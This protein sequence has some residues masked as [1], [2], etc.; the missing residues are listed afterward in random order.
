MCNRHTLHSHVDMR[1]RTRHFM[2]ENPQTTSYS[3]VDNQQNHI[4]C[5]LRKSAKQHRKLPLYHDKDPTTNRTN[6]LCC[7]I[8]G[9]FNQT[10]ITSKSRTLHTTSHTINKKPR[11][12]T[13]VIE[14]DFAVDAFVM[15]LNGF[16]I[17]TCDVSDRDMQRF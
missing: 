12:K 2:L 4:A 14:S 1:L 13:I 7:I 16:E 5:Q 17:H 6:T 8:F 15:K 9:L 3:N 11:N 10:H